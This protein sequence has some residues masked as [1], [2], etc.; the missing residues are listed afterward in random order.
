MEVTRRL[1]RISIATLNP[2]ILISKP[3]FT[4]GRMKGKNCRRNAIHRRRENQEI[5]KQLKRECKQNI[6]TVK[7]VS[8]K[9]ELE[10]AALGNLLGCPERGEQR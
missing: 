4:K 7:I 8:L 3:S 2:Y 9:R 5:F 1:Q 10:K 6:E